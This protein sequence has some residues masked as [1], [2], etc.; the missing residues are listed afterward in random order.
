MNGKTSVQLVDLHLFHA[1]VLKQNPYDFSY[2]I[3]Q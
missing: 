3:L 2:P 1:F